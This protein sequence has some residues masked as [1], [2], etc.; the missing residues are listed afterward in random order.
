MVVEAKLTLELKQGGQQ[1][2]QCRL[3]PGEACV[4]LW[5]EHDVVEVRWVPRS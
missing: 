2:Q 5:D 1:A 4:L 3:L